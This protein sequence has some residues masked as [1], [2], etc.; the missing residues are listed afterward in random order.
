MLIN[1][2]IVE[3][4]VSVV[5]DGFQKTFQRRGEITNKGVKRDNNTSS[6]EI[7][8]RVKRSRDSDGFRMND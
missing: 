5:E 8:T 1:F 2:F 6:S 7:S 3:R 4:F